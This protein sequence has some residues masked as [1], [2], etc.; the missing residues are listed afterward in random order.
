MPWLTFWSH[1]YNEWK[2]YA[3]FI[4]MLFI[5][6]DPYI[7]Q[8]HPYT[9]FLFLHEVC[10]DT[11]VETYS[12]NLRAVLL[13]VKIIYSCIIIIIIIFVLSFCIIWLTMR[14]TGWKLCFCFLRISFC[15]N[16]KD[17]Y[18]EKKYNYFN[19]LWWIFPYYRCCIHI[20]CFVYYICLIIR[21]VS[22]Y[23][24]SSWEII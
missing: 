13:Y 21:T 15:F 18:I 19:P 2:C 24:L 7:Q 16:F 3:K 8:R 23:L 17:H 11:L 4:F 10:S 22:I 6:I 1:A 5:H 20:V 9:L 12:I 14:Q